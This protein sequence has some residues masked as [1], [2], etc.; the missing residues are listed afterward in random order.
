MA[1]SE[2]DGRYQLDTSK[3][4]TELGLGFRDADQTVIDTMTSLE[5]WRHLGKKTK[6]GAAASRQ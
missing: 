6:V 4:R 3:T 5:N 1:R 2:A